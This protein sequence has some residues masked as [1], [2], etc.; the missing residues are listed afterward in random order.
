MTR[1]QTLA[2]GA[3][4]P[5]VLTTLSFAQ[6]VP[7][8]IL[9]VDLENFV[10]YQQDFGDATKFAM[11]LNVPT[12]P[13]IRNFVPFVFLGDV[14]AVNGKP[15]KGTFTVRGTQ[16]ARTTALSPGNAIADSASGT[17]FDCVVDISYI[18]GTQIGTIMATGWGGSAK[19]PGAPSSFVASNYTITGGTGAFLGVRGQ[20]GQGATTVAGRSTS[21]AEDP[22]YR[23]INGGG[24]RTYIFHLLPME[25]PEIVNVW[26]SDFTPV[27][28]AKPARADEVLTVSA[29]GLGPTR[30]GVDPGAPF[31]QLPTLQVVNSPVDVTFGGVPAEVINQVGWPGQQNLYRVDFRVPKTSGSM[32]QV[33]LT[34]AWI[35]GAAITIPVQ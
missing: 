16:I 29:R 4:F 2:A 15:A 26:H 23:R 5:L 34:V 9:A 33:Q 19:A 7:A 8:A 30:P 18:D 20:G 25:R 27:T 13:A 10:S 1:M 35:G 12:L 31:P 14:V 28:A 32:A 3:L 24:S 6:A 22:A 17:Y 11:D 21:V